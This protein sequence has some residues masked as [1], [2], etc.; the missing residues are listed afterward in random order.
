VLLLVREASPNL[1]GA[2]LGGGA[3]SRNKGKV[4]LLHRSPCALYCCHF[5][6]FICGCFGGALPP[7]RR[8]SMPVNRFVR[9]EPGSI[10]SSAYCSFLC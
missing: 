10:G 8:I 4:R 5:F 1:A 7:A 2:D 9:G 3:R 6:G